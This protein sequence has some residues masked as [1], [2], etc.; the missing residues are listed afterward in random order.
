M[1]FS[2]LWR[3]TFRELLQSAHASCER[4]VAWLQRLADIA[5]LALAGWPASGPI[6]AEELAPAAVQPLSCLEQALHLLAGGGPMLQG[7]LD[8]PEL[9]DDGLEG[10]GCRRRG[11]PGRGPPPAGGR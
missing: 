8:G 4:G 5:E 11:P 2:A 6:A 10:L 9:L 1:T 3:T 7:G